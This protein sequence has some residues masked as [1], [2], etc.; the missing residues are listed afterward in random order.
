MLDVLKNQDKIKC[1]AQAELA[2]KPGVRFF[3]K[4]DEVE[5]YKE[6]AAR[7]KKMFEKEKMRRMQVH[8]QE[9]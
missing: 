5:E 1:V 4:E 3:E 6:E 2:L 8:Q 9:E 7:E